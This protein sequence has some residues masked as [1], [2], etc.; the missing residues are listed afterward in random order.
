M[1]PC[2]TSAADDRLELLLLNALERG[3]DEGDLS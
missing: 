3:G 2:S 1:A